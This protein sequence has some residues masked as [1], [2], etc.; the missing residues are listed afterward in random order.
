MSFAG[1]KPKLIVYFTAAEGTLAANTGRANSGIDSSG[2]GFHLQ[3]LVTFRK[4][5]AVTFAERPQFVLFGDSITQRSFDISGFG[6]SL[7]NRYCRKADVVL[8]GYSGYN[9]RWATFMLDRLFPVDSSKPPLLVTV[10]FGANDAAFPDRGKRAQHVP[11]PEY[12]DNLRKIVAHLKKANVKHIVLISPPPIDEEGRVVYARATYGEEAN[13]LPERT[14]QQ[15]GLYAEAAESVARETGVIPL[16]LWSILQKTTGWQKF[17]VD[18]LHL[19]HEG[20]QEVFR[21]LLNILDEPSLKPSLNWESFP[22]DYP[23]WDY[24]D[25]QDPAKSLQPELEN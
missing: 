18:G 17:L 3:G 16:N 10:F 24:I 5:M 7:A 19:S 8:R 20:N 25:Y 12:K 13:E 21:N 22:W 4:E 2:R 23:E 14:N 1:S 9:T 11:L 15:T 6:A